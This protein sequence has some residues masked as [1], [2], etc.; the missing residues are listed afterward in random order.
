[1]ENL[2]KY[3]KALGKAGVYYGPCLSNCC[4]AM[5]SVITKAAVRREI[6]YLGLTFQ[7]QRSFIIMAS[8]QGMVVC[9]EGA[10]REL[11]HEGGGEGE[12]EER[13][14]E[15]SRELELRSFSLWLLSAGSKGGYYQTQSEVSW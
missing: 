11:H 3:V 2:K 14:A 6:I 13:V 1:M 9:R 5:K 10:E 4:I 8:W 12:R 15:W 7:F